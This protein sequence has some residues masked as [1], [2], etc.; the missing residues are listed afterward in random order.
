MT[1][2]RNYNECVT[3]KCNKCGTEYQF[4][5]MRVIALRECK[6]GNSNWGSPRHWWDDDF[7]DFTLVK[8]EIVELRILRHQRLI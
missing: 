2:N 3:V 7:G 5:P 6:C 1:D 8:R 4:Y